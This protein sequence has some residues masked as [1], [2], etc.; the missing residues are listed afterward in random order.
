[1]TR[2]IPLRTR[3]Q[4]FLYL[5]LCVGCLVSVE[6]A[7][8]C[9][10]ASGISFREYVLTIPAV[11][12]PRDAVVGTLLARVDTAA[13]PTSGNYAT[14]TSPGTITRVV[15]GTSQVSGAP[16]Y[17]YAT[18]VAG[19]GIRYFEATPDY[20]FVRYWGQ[21]VSESYAGAW[22]WGGGRLGVELVVTGKVSSGVISAPPVAASSLDG[23]SIASIRL[24]SG[25]TITSK[26]CNVSQANTS[27]T[28]PTV[29]VT[30]FPQVGSVAEGK[31]FSLGFDCSSPGAAQVFITFTD[32]TLP[33]N[34]TNL[35]TLSPASTS[36]GLKLQLLRNGV[37]VY[38]G[39]DASEAGTINQISLGSSANLYQLPLT[40]RYVRTGTVTAGS[41]SA[42][43]TFTLSYQ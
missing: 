36:G 28:L 27:V 41:V 7:A 25:T 34:R 42:V 17:T 33:S 15:T 30:D 13:L 11:S 9:T 2:N 19:V 20:S 24:A 43:A 35:L 14:C 38:F 23:L 5:L 16:S 39:P 32:G 31:S 18:G 6:A 12:V 8:T 3:K 40:V 22:G 37:P 29:R 1:M 10:F 21:G 26:T 4:A